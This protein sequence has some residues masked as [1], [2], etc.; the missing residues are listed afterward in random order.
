M[1]NALRH[2]RGAALDE[3]TAG[4]KVFVEELD[5]AH[6]RDHRPLWLLPEAAVPINPDLFDRVRYATDQLVISAEQLVVVGSWVIGNV[7]TIDEALFTLRQA[8]EDEEAPLRRLEDDLLASNFQKLVLITR[9]TLR[10]AIRDV[11]YEHSGAIYLTG[12]MEHLE[13]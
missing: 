4:V 10:Q 2:E 9:R 13:L 3:L 5:P 7:R 8:L 1:L 11:R 6:E 12:V